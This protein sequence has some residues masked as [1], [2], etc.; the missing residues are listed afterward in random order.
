[1]KNALRTFIAAWYLLGW[2]V[3]VFLAITSPQIYEGFGTTGLIPGYDQFWTNWIMPHISFLAILLAAFE[4]CVGLMIV[5]KGKWVK[6]GLAFSIA[7]NLFLVQMGLCAQTTTFWS[8]FLN[9][10]LPNLIMVMLQLP[11]LWGT[12][13]HTIIESIKVKRNKK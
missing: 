7:F 9:N 6:I 3:H 11:L 1:M 12:Y 4:L 2:M 5:N 10:R 8:D 13:T